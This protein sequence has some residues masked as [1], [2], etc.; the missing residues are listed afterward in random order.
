MER[1]GSRQTPQRSDA[2]PRLIAFYLP[3][4]QIACYVNLYVRN[5]RFRELARL[6]AGHRAVGWEML[7]SAARRTVL[8]AVRRPDLR[9][10]RR[11]PSGVLPSPQR[12]S[13]NGVPRRKTF[14]RIPG[15]RRPQG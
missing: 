11:S 12:G 5:R 6:V 1:L 7:Q 8:E 15:N 9:V 3:Q 10:R 13:R 4:Y 14:V 2:S